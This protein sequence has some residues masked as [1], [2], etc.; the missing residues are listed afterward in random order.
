MRRLDRS[1]VVI[2]RIISRSR[3]F[4]AAVNIRWGD[5][6]KIEDYEMQEIA[7]WDQTQ[8][9]NYIATVA[10]FNISSTASTSHKQLPPVYKDLWDDLVS[11]KKVLEDETY[12]DQ[13]KLFKCIAETRLSSGATR[14]SSRAVS[15]VPQ[16]SIF[17][18][19]DRIS[20]WASLKLA[21]NRL[22]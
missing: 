15:S 11:K 2:F 1:A 3:A 5:T 17:P 16:L 4:R 13:L 20:N 8:A 6:G 18:I 12:R 21:S 10:L 22:R 14:V 19:A 9:Y 7:C